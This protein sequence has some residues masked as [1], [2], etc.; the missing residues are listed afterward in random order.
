MKSINAHDQNPSRAAQAFGMRTRGLP[1]RR[2]RH[3]ARLLSALAGVLLLG[4][5]GSP[6]LASDTAGFSPWL[7][8][9]DEAKTSAKK[10]GQYILVDLYADW[11]GWCKKLEHE[12]FTSDA[13]RQFA[14]DFVLLRVDVEDRG[15]GSKLQADYR[16]SSLPT[17]LVLDA[18]GIEVGTVSGYFPTAGYIQA[19]RRQIGRYEGSLKHFEQARSSGDLSA[20]RNLAEVLHRRRDGERAAVI[21]DRM[22]SL[23]NT[24]HERLLVLTMA[25]DAQRIAGDFSRA[26]RTAGEATE[27]A[28]SLEQPVLSEQVELLI[29]QIAQDTGDCDQAEQSLQTFLRAHPKSPMRR[30][31]RQ[32]L[33]ALRNEAA[34]G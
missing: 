4:L 23:D 5:S 14:K 20:L 24:P 16:I 19:L 8:H 10:G 31:A 17:M 7:S 11:C 18:R 6:A 13:F 9:P 32:L 25:I 33:S 28:T 30:Q 34:C 15:V 1:R 26:R 22:L 27:L 12:V 29:A 21:Y 3:T 2:F